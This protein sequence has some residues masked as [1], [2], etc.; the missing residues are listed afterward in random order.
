MLFS[1]SPFSFGGGGKGERTP[2][3]TCLSYLVIDYVSLARRSGGIWFPP[4]FSFTPNPPPHFSGETNIPAPPFTN[5]FLQGAG[6]G[7]G[8]STAWMVEMPRALGNK[9]NCEYFPRY[10]CLR[11]FLSFLRFDKAPPLARD[12]TDKTVHPRNDGRG[13]HF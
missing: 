12:T 4:S 5:N 9:G 7:R 11:I 3:F 8:S 2:L 1:A 13:S 6:K 10:T